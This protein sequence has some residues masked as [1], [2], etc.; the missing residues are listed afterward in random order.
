MKKN[1]LLSFLFL[2]PVTLRAADVIVKVKNNIPLQRQQ[3]V[4]VDLTTVRQRLGISN[5]E[6]FIVKNSLQQQVA[7]Q[8]SYDNKLLIEIP[9]RPL[10]ETR[11]TITK[12]I[13]EPMTTWVQGK[14][15]R[16][17]KDDIAWEND[18]GAYRVYGPSLQKSGEKS[19]GI[20]IWTKSIPQLDVSERY[21][22]DMEGNITGYANSKDGKKDQDINLHTSFHLDHGTGLDCYSVGPTLGCG[23]PALMDGNKL[24]Y[25]YCYKDYK[26]LDNGPLRFTVELTYNTTK[27][28]ND[29]VTEHRIISLDK[30]SNFNRMTVWYDGLSKPHDLASGVVL[31]KAD[32]NSV[33]IG[34]NFVQYADPTDKPGEGYQLYVA[35]IFPEG[36]DTRKILFDQPE[37]DAIGHAL[38][39]KKNLKNQERYTYYFGSA[40]SMY[41][42]R[43]QHEWQCRIDDFMQCLARP[44]T[45]TLE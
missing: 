2:L 5:S 27:I 40:W 42:V 41:D 33:V 4:E 29:E 15:Y 12:G 20:D 45:V 37:G 35:A 19:Y 36:A 18:R 9:V 14:L 32:S 34:K 24:I 8:I 17:R 22:K 28:G 38:G 31:H 25:P 43:T 11:Y 13:P 10:G 6:T 39:I 26:I 23:T 16:I 1:I 3:L 30:G 44:V 7:Y 21:Y